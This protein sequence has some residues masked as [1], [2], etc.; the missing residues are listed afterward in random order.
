MLKFGQVKHNNKN[1]YEFVLS[2]S[3]IFA[4]IDFDNNGNLIIDNDNFNANLSIVENYQNVNSISFIKLIGWQ[5]SSTLFIGF[6]IFSLILIL[7]FYFANTNYKLTHN[8]LNF[9]FTSIV[10]VFI[11]YSIPGYALGVLLLSMWGGDLFPL[12]GWRSTADV[13]NN[14]TFFGK[15][16]DQVWHAFL[17][18]LCYVVGS[19]ATLTVLM[20][21]SLMEN[22]SQDYVRT[23]F[24]KGLSEKRVIFYHAVRN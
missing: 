4:G 13:W 12:Y 22:L 21:N 8:F 9:V 7:Y 23:A 14:L 18:I 10:L 24:A 11:G 3:S 6:L 20:K 19:F 16:A 17:P 15:I 2:D 1:Q 5:E